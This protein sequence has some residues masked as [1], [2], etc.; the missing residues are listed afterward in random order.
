VQRV[1]QRMRAMKAMAGD[2]TET[3]EVILADLLGDDADD[4]AA[5]PGVG[6]TA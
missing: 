2:D 6:W 4:R 5:R 1:L 3:L